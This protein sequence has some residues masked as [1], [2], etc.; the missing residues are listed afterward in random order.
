MR[1][2]ITGATGNV[3]TALIRA[4][5]ADE[6]VA[7]IVGIA[8][9]AP[10]VRPPKTTWHALDVA[11]DDL[12]PAFEGA[13]AVVHLAWAIQPSRDPRALWRTNVVG[14][15]RVFEAAAEAGVGALVHASSVGVYSPGPK[16]RAVDESWPRSGTPSSDYARHKAEA[17]R[18]LDEVE[19]SAPGMR[20]VRMRPGLCFSR[21][22]ASGVRRLFAG[23]LLPPFAARP[24]RIARVPDIPGL[25]FQAVH[26]DDAAQA[27]RLALTRDV[28]GAFNV[29]AE[30][31]LDP[32]ALAEALDAGTIRV[33]AGLARSLV[34]ITWRLRLQPTG[35]GWLDMA[36]AVPIMDTARARR[37]LG[38]APRHTSAQALTE[39]L[40][41]VADRAGAPTPPLA[42]HGDGQVR[43]VR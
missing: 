2:V 40:H 35:P 26:S 15:G 28:S 22:A 4:L 20:V 39:L 36:L 41:G 19:R 5:L 43:V 42:P 12:G 37:A 7:E 8:R 31:F 6:A 18:R 16:H 13:D 3:G 23:R 10:A 29:A 32:A 25:R 33:P 27:Y 34:W 9:R 38:W 11:S 1:V 14:S 24:S 30:P 17:E 21:E